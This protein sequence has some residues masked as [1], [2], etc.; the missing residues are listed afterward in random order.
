MSHTHTHTHMACPTISPPL[1]QA[2]ASFYMEESQRFISENAITDYM[3]KVRRDPPCPSPRH[4]N[5]A[6]G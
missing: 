1:L 2:T 6:T 4:A 3:K 5:Q